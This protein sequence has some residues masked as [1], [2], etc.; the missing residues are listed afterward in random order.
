MLDKFQLLIESFV[1]TVKVNQQPEALFKNDWRERINQSVQR[2]LAE[3]RLNIL[4]LNT[5][6]KKELVLHL[7][8]Q[9]AFTGK[10]TA[11]YIAQILN[12]SRASVYNYL[13]KNKRN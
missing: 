11:H 10:N 5:D 7:H 6:Q 3:K 9:G 12:I 8:A 4:S 1:G 2:Y 13:K